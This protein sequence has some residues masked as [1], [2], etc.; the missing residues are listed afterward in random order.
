M[1]LSAWRNQSDGHWTDAAYVDRLF[2]LFFDFICPLCIRGEELQLVRN[3]CFKRQKAAAAKM[4][5]STLDKMEGINM[6]I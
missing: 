6:T 5:T 3:D 4:L 2:S 1:S